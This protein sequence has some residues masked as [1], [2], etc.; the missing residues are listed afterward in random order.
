MQFTYEGRSNRG[1]GRLPHRV[2]FTVTS[3]TQGD[4]RR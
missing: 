1:Q 3:L 2:V 4:R